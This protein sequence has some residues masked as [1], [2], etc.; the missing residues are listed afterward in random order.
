MTDTNF[1]KLTRSLF[2]Q[3][4]NARHVDSWIYSEALGFDI[5]T[6]AKAEHRALAELSR[7]PWL[8]L[9]VTTA[10]QALR[11]GDIT[12]NGERVE[13]L[14]RLWVDNG[15]KAQQMAF[16][17][18]VL[19]YGNAFTVTTLGVDGRAKI[20]FVSPTRCAVIY[21]DPADIYPVQAI[22]V[23][24]RKGDRARYWL[25]SPGVTQLVEVDNRDPDGR[26]Y[27][28][29]EEFETGLDVVPVVEACNQRTLDG[30]VIGEVTPLIPTAQRINKS[31]YDRLLMQ[32]FN[33]WRVRYA[34]GID[35][36]REQVNTP[37]IQAYGVGAESSPAPALPSVD[38]LD[39]MGRKKPPLNAE[40]VEKVKLR[41]AQDDFLISDSPET[42]FGTLEASSMDD[43]ISAFKTDVES[44]AAVSQ[45][46]AHALVGS[47]INVSGDALAEARAPLT[48]KISER[49]EMIGDAFVRT[50]KIAAGLMGDNATV[51]DP[52]LTISWRDMEIRSLSQAADALG[53]ASQMLE[54][55]ARG[56]WDRIPGTDAAEL[57]KWEKLHEEETKNDPL[58]ALARRQTTPIS[59]PQFKAVS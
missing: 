48:Q 32:H 31:A 19:A 11:V 38:P 40:E 5:P 30:K 7:T 47:M 36:P 25:Y 57:Q 49:Q 52:Y 54:I 42:S 56:L 20:R 14:Y 22:E 34:T 15:L 3:Q 26:G 18:A 51:E 1:A 28:V 27:V 16:Y 2:N 23:A 59:E 50:L 45:T 44:L 12:S 9:V 33:S 24:P 35:L 41:L 43:I 10:A 55:P 6:K 17:R 8:G 29:L 13:D 46:P 37:E 39:P 21:N 4:I 53:K 58:A